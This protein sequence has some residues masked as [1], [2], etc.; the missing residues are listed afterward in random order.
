MPPYRKG[1]IGLLHFSANASQI[2]RR[3]DA[4]TRDFF[5]Y[6]NVNFFAVPQHA[7]LFEHLNMLKR[8]W[9][10]VDVA[11]DKPGAIAVD[12]DVT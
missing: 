4:R 5:G 7:Q 11:A 6:G 12:S 10:P 9:C 3:I 1:A 2:F 8:A